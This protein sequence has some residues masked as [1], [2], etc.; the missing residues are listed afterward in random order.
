MGET[1]QLKMKYDTDNNGMLDY[2]ELCDMV[3][4]GD[5]DVYIEESLHL[6]KSK[7]R[8]SMGTSNSAMTLGGGGSTP[9]AV[10]TEHRGKAPTPT[11]GEYLST[12][13]LQARCAGTPEH[14]LRS[15]M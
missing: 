6:N 2:M 13:N 9:A 3:Y 11:I 12:T 1:S 15:A 5:F 14:Q 8:G 7:S 4:P 10:S